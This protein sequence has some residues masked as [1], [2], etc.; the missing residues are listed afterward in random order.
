MKATQKFEIRKVSYLK[1]YLYIQIKYILYLKI[2]SLR[3]LEYI[4]LNIRLKGR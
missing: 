1:L 4:K 2:L 3:D